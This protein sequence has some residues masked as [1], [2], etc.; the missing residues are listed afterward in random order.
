MKED[1][2]N[3][4]FIDVR[5]FFVSDSKAT[6]NSSEPSF[7]YYTDIHGD[8]RAAISYL[9]DLGYIEDITPG[10]CPKYRFYEHFIDN[11][12]NT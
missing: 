9:E 10:N 8:I 3:P 7:R 11:L 6:I 4:E 12:R 2:N 1:V 5:T